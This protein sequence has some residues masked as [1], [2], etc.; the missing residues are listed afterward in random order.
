MEAK[1]DGD[2]GE[3]AARDLI[4]SFGEEGEVARVLDLLVGEEKGEDPFFTD[5]GGCES[6]MVDLV[7]LR[8]LP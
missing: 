5:G 3:D 8:A 2:T 1:G 4:N 7:R 6:R